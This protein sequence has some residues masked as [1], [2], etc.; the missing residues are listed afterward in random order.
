MSLLPWLGAFPAFAFPIPMR[1]NEIRLQ[2]LTPEQARGFPIP[3]RG[4]EH[5]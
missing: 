5:W 2:H 3:M 1:G 4:N